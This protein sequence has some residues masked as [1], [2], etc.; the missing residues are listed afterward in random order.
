MLDLSTAPPPSLTPTTRLIIIYLRMMGP[1]TYRELALL[2][3]TK[4]E[5]LKVLVRPLVRAG[6]VVRSTRKAVG[7]PSEFTVDRSMRFK[8]GLGAAPG[9]D[10]IREFVIKTLSAFETLEMWRTWAREMDEAEAAVVE[11]GVVGA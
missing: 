4:K 10:T 8:V 11:H 2:T 6:F 3:G 9:W 1:C 5:T 7:S